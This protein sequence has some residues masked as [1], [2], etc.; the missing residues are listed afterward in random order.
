[1]KFHR[2]QISRSLKRYI[3]LIKQELRRKVLISYSVIGKA[4]DRPEFFAF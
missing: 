1:M 2:G 4:F 3:N